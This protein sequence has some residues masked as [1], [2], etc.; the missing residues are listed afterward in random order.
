M[1]FRHGTRR[2]KLSDVNRNRGYPSAEEVSLSDD[3][4]ILC[5]IQASVRSARSPGRVDGEEAGQ[6]LMRA[7]AV[8]AL[9]PR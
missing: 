4:G 7:P 5:A 3:V 2:D 6:L 1:T 9:A 8:A